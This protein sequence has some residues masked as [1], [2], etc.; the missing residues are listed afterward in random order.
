MLAIKGVTGI[1]KRR[2]GG[3]KEELEAKMGGWVRYI[4]S[5]L[6]LSGRRYWPASCP[7]R[8]AEMPTMRPMPCRIY[9]VRSSGW[10]GS[11]SRRAP[12]YRLVNG[13]LVMG[14]IV[15]HFSTVELARGSQADC[16]VN[17]E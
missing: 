11:M 4:K 2:L 17:T 1:S 13:F 7:A 10:Y 12:T 14:G 6:L 8:E 16:V 3:E 9:S 15:S 5:Y